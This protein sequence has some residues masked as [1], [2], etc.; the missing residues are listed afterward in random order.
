MPRN[1]SLDEYGHE[2]FYR[3]DRNG[4]IK[5]DSLSLLTDPE[6]LSQVEVGN[7][8]AAQVA[9]VQKLAGTVPQIDPAITTLLAEIEKLK[10]RLEE[11]Q[12]KKSDDAA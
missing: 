10:A 8:I 9:M 6:F 1:M 2:V 11:L 12:G 5:V 3:H 7:T 4:N